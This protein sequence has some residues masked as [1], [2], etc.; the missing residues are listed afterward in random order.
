MVG[1][2]ALPT[3]LDGFNKYDSVILS[4]VSALRISK[5]QMELVRSYVRDHGGGLVMLG[6]E[7][8]FGVG[9]Y[10]HTPVEEALPVTMEARQKVEI[11]SLAVVLVHRS[12]GQHG[13]ERR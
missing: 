1:P 12:V 10:Y 6:G 7:E 3:S 5:R 2:E 9:G 4:N 8:S 11:P 13:D